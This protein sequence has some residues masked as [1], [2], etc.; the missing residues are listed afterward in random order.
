[1]VNDNEQGGDAGTQKDSDD[2]RRLRNVVAEEI[3]AIMVKHDVGGV[4]FLASKASG[5]WRFV[6]PKWSVLQ[7]EGG[8][9]MRFKGTT[10]TPEGRDLFEST[11]HYVLCVRDMSRDCAA[12]YAD[13]FRCIEQGLPPGAIEH[14]NPFRG[15]GVGRSGE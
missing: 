15:F 8:M 7:L 4:V 9:R 10:R 1:V 6:L 12:L 14:S 5:A 13:L 3:E 11:L 2:Q